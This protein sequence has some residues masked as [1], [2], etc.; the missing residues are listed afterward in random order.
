MVVESL[1]VESLKYGE[2]EISVEDLGTERGGM[3]IEKKKE[4]ANCFLLLPPHF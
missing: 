4:R 1:N 2:L 3:K